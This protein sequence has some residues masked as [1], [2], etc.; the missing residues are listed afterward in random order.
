M[1]DLKNDISN[2]FAFATHF[3]FI[4]LTLKTHS[5]LFVAIATAFTHDDEIFF[6]HF[7]TKNHVDVEKQTTE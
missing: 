3:V 7:K 5:N 1:R 6:V 2:S 4:S